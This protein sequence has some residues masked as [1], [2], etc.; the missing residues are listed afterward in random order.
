MC[1]CEETFALVKISYSNI[2][3]ANIVLGNGAKLKYFGTREINGNKI[4][5]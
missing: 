1:K 4:L 5:E 3:I 2:N